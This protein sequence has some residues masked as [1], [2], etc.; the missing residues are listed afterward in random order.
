MLVVV[1]ETSPKNHLDIF[2][3]GGLPRNEE[4]YLQGLFFE[5]HLSNTNGSKTSTKITML[6]D[7]DFQITD[8]WASLSYM[9][10]FF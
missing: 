5:H 4:S 3:L 7:M 10:G 2:T 8:L 6:K 1:E 9:P